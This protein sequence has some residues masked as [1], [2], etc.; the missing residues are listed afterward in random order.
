MAADHPDSPPDLTPRSRTTGEWHDTPSPDA[1][2]TAAP[3]HVAIPDY[4]ILGELGRGGKGV[5]YKARHLKLNRV[6]ALKMILAAGYA[7]ATDLARFRAEAEA[8]ASLQHP[9]VVQ[10]FE[11]NEA[12]GLPYLSFELCAGSLADRLDGTPWA[13]RR[14]AELIE[15]LAWAIHAAHRA[16]V[17]HRDLKPGNVLLAEDGTPKV[18][19]F[20]L[21]KRIDSA[22]LTATGDILGT[23]SYM[24]PEQV[25]G[26]PGLSAGRSPAAIGP[27]ADVYALGAILY[28]LLTGRPPFLA[29]T[30]LDTLLQVVLDE[31]LSP[32]R[33]QPGVPRDL[34]TTCLKCLEK[35]PARRYPSAE[36]LAEDLQ[37][38]QYDLPIRARPARAWERAGK[39]AKRHPAAA[40]VATVGAA[41]AL[42]LLAGGLYFTDRL[43][44]E[45]DYARRAEALASAE[46]T[47][48]RHRNYVLAMGQ[49]QLA[50][51]Q[52][53]LG[54]LRKLLQDQIPR[55]G[56]DDLR[57]FEW[58]YWDRLARGAPRVLRLDGSDSAVEAVAYSPDG[59]LLAGAGRGGRGYLWDAST[60]TRI[61]VI[62]VRG[63]SLTCLAFTPD[64]RRIAFGGRSAVQLFDLETAEQGPR[65]EFR[66]GV[67]GIAF[68]PGGNR[69][70][71]RGGGQVSLWD[72]TGDAPLPLRS[73]RA[74][75]PDTTCGLEFSPDGRTLAAGG[76]P[77]RLWDVETGEEL[78]AYPEA[79]AEGRSVTFSPDGGR[80]ATSALNQV[81][82][83]AEIR[84]VSAASGAVLTRC[85]GHTDDS[86]CV[87]F[88]PD[89]RSLASAGYDNTIRLWDADTG[90]ELRRFQGLA[91]RN[92]GVAFSPG[93]RELAA[94]GGSGVELW[95]I[96]FEQD[97]S[98]L[99]TP[100]AGVRG[101]AL[102]ADTGRVLSVRPDGGFI[103][104]PASRRTL[105]Q[106]EGGFSAA[107]LATFD[108]G[109]RLLA[110]DYP[111][112]VVALWE[113][114]TGRRLRLFS[115]LRQTHTI[116][117]L[118]L[119][120]D[121]RR[122]VAAGRADPDPGRAAQ[123]RPDGPTDEIIV[124][125]TATGA[126]LLRMREQVDRVNSLAAAADSPLLLAGGAY[127]SARLWDTRTGRLLHTLETV[128]AQP[129]GG[130]WDTVAALSPDSP[131]GR[132]AAFGPG[133][134]ASPTILL[135]DTGAARLVHRLEGH[136]R[137]LR[138][139]AFSADG[140]R[141]ASASDDQT[142]KL[143]DV[144]TGQEVLSRP[145]PHFA[146]DVAFTS[147]G[148]RLL[149]LAVD[150]T[151]RTWD[152]APT[153]LP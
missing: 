70:A 16:G 66:D 4:E 118:V 36:A 29:S 106:L 82:R 134:P 12:G 75:G 100:A 138:R 30:H 3:G 89:G 115:D 26:L 21:A 116:T 71:T 102:H 109:G 77:G 58:Y 85:Q 5:V 107:T 137:G 119:T 37:R 132:H 20:G 32:S 44:A 122:L 18:A 39:W 50:W 101:L 68:S 40:G 52:A 53:A 151:L 23:P 90:K 146:V 76:P 91:L 78:E 54:R 19:D 45:R 147:D 35:E 63:G 111:G 131:D 48:G 9:N 114:A 74:V 88:S 112:G 67:T 126:T 13:P 14:A 24:A 96:D 136:L 27:P 120:A 73:W 142:V 11:I 108:R 7:S 104:D 43:K 41:A 15:T 72:L 105:A 84:V 125:D 113:V 123:P 94:A 117:A 81:T 127:P 98:T 34:E 59:R 65:V 79:L 6:V 124:W 103:T 2:A 144:A 97:A 150:G 95:P 121:G 55:P 22:G 47:N 17:V 49:A 135:Y 31:P 87:R 92:V 33:L 80:L 149:A 148:R 129:G 46:A 69:M 130:G 8:A 141:L 51:Q 83:T 62:D 60:A 25:G 93:G 38:Y 86:R 61:R 99:P 143:W 42:A 64:G 110:A 133:D 10:V 1:G 57:G 153:P 128:A 140:Q 145:V 152:A 28:E 139:L 56:E